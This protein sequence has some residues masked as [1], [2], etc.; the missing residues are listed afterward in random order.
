[1]MSLSSGGN[2]YKNKYTTEGSSALT[3][4]RVKTPRVLDPKI[5]NNPR[6][7]TSVI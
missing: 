7:N 5:N 2:F 1:M 4:S 6:Q 3:S